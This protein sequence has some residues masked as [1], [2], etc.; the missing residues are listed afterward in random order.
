MRARATTSILLLRPERL[1]VESASDAT[2]ATQLC[3]LSIQPCS[4]TLLQPDDHQRDGA[5][6]RGR[7]RRV[8][9]AGWGDAPPE[10]PVRHNM[11]IV[12]LTRHV[13]TSHAP[14]FLS[15]Q[16]IGSHSSILFS[17]GSMI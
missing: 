2:L 7:L 5:W 4:T 8:D 12:P 13:A 10:T 1:P 3:S 6:A 17:S 16:T 14:L 15:S 11:R 9:P